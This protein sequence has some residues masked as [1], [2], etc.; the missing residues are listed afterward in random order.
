V[1]C[2]ALGSQPQQ[3]FRA[4]EPA[5]DP[6]AIL[7]NDF[8]AVS[9]A[10]LCDFFRK[11]RNLFFPEHQLPEDLLVLGGGGKVRL[12]EIEPAVLPDNLPVKLGDGFARHCQH[13][14][15]QGGCINTVLA[16]NVAADGH[17]AGGFTADDCVGL[18]HFAGYMLEAHRYLVAFLPKIQG[19]PVQQ[20][21]GGNVPD[22]GPLP[23]PVF[24]KI[25]VKDHQQHIGMEV[26]A[27]FID[28][29]Q[30]VRIAVGG[31]A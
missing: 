19:H 16:L 7:K 12:P 11:F 24:Q 17:A 8:A 21:G 10:D 28:D 25:I 5:N 26:I 1:V 29:T 15:H 9:I 20:M 13:L 4:G 30:P 14:H 22:A 6:A 3:R 23:A 2:I 27:L 31:D 18:N